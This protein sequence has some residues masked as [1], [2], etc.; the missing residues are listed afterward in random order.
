MHNEDMQEIRSYNKVVYG[1]QEIAKE[2]MKL[3]W[4]HRMD[5]ISV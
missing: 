4:C 3:P 5:I 2:V 1:D